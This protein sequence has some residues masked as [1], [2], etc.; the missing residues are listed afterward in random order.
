MSSSWTA[1]ITKKWRTEKT[2]R[3]DLIKPDNKKP[4]EQ[5]AGFF[6]AFI[7][8][9]E[10]LVSVFIAQSAMHLIAITTPNRGRLFLISTC[11]VIYADF[12]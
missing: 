9:L 7:K 8:R 10:H 5:S 4:A 6:M 11:L 2:G 1:R 3:L 12:W